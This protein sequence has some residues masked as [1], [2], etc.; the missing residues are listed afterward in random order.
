MFPLPPN[1]AFHALAYL[2]PVSLCD[3]SCVLSLLLSPGGAER[4]QPAA[5]PARG[6]EGGSDSEAGKP[7]KGETVISST[8][9]MASLEVTESFC[10]LSAWLGL[11][12]VTGPGNGCSHPH[13]APL[14]SMMQGEQLWSQG[15]DSHLPTFSLCL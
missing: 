12:G 8:P 13:P 4:E 14:L 1:D 5:R 3:L 6:Q 7:E 11:R 2:L 9:P 10:I 15:I